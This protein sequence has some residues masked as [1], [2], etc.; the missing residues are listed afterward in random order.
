[1][2][3]KIAT[4]RLGKRIVIKIIAIKNKEDDINIY[5]IAITKQAGTVTGDLTQFDNKQM[6][7]LAMCHRLVSS[8]YILNLDI[9]NSKKANG[10]TA[11]QYPRGSGLHKGDEDTGEH[12]YKCSNTF[13]A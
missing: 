2:T 5:C 7:Q 4:K 11:G 3:K 12:T 10:R 1:M 8:D 13:N 9:V 6:Q